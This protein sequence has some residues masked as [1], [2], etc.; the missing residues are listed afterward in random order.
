M[1]FH[2]DQDGVFL[3]LE[4]LDVHGA[5]LGRN[6]SGLALGQGPAAQGWDE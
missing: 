4:A 1:A 2:S 6:D 5:K 3:N